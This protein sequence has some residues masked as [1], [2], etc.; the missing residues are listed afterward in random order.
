MSIDQLQELEAL[1]AKVARYEAPAG[2]QELQWRDCRRATDQGE[3]RQPMRASY[4][5]GNGQWK[6]L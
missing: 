5:D 1:R 4:T 3:F 6:Q 2:W